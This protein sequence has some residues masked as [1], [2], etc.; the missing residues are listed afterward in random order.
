MPDPVLWAYQQLKKTLGQM[1]EEAGKLPTARAKLLELCRQKA[2]LPNLDMV[3]RYL[4]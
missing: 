4:L 1:T 2:T 3:L